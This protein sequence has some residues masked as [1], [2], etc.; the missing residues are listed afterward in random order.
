ML[1]V[2]AD[3]TSGTGAPRLCSRCQCG[4]PS[5]V[6]APVAHQLTRMHAC[7]HAR[8]H[9][10]MSSC[11]LG[12]RHFVLPCLEALKKFLIWQHDTLR[13]L[14]VLLYVLG[15]GVWCIVCCV[16]C[17]VSLVCLVSCVLCAVY[18]V[19]C[20]VCVRARVLCRIASM[21]PGS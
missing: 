18:C 4:R 6:W 20:A 1:R 13:I 7:T 10:R 3:C 2:T 16:M 11:V 9:T 21:R 12:S 15:C 14:S 8:M 19:L 17:D 5:G